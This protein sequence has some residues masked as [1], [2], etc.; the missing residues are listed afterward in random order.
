[1]QYSIRDYKYVRYKQYQRFCVTWTFCPCFCLHLILK[2]GLGGEW[3]NLAQDWEKCQ[4]VIN[5]VMNI[6]VV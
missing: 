6:Q 1:M 3:I 5:M 2:I 4:A